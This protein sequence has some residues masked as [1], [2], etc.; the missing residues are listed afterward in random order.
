MIRPDMQV[1]RIGGHRPTYL[2]NDSGTRASQASISKHGLD[3]HSIATDI[4]RE[5]IETPN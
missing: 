2:K 5:I 4:I 1:K 3:K